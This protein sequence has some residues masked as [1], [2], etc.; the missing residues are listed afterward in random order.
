MTINEKQGRRK[1]V[2]RPRSTKSWGSVLKYTLNTDFQAD[3]HIHS[4]LFDHQSR[5]NGDISGLVFDALSE[6]MEKHQSRFRDMEECSKLAVSAVSGVLPKQ[7]NSEVS[8]PVEQ[9]WTKEE[10]E[11]LKEGVMAGRSQGVFIIDPPAETKPEPPTANQTPENNI[12]QLLANMT[13]EERAAFIQ[14]FNN[15]GQSASQPQATEE[16]AAVAASLGG[17]L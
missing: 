14:S 12:H 5:N 3:P 2:G 4:L 9:N 11:Q 6:Y 15:G 17:E 13:P 10:A 8:V 16:A 1:P 7:K